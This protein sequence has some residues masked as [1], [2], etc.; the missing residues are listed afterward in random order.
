M[1]DS[2]LH[3]SQT[4]VGLS[5]AQE[6]GYQWFFWVQAASSLLIRHIQDISPLP[7]SSEDGQCLEGFRMV[8]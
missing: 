3:G 7:G 4:E 8:T 5:P 1:D 2:F 6:D